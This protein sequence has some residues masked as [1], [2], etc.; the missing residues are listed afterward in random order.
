MSLTSKGAQPAQDG[1]PT[2]RGMNFFLEDRNLQFLCESVMGAA[3]FERARPHLVEMGEVAGGELDDLAAQAD[4]N[5][6]VLRAFDQAG[7]RVDEVVFHPSYRRM[8]TIAFERFGLAALS[9]RDGVLGW[10]GRVPQTVKYALSY[11]FAQSEFGLLCPVNMTDSTARMLKHYASDELKAAW[12]P[13]LTTTDFPQLLQGTQWMTEKTGG[14]DVG[15]ATTLARKGADG[16]WRLWGDKWFCSNAN[17]DVALTLARPE[18][19][20]KGTRG[21]GMFLVP[22]YLPDGTKNGWVINRLKDKFGSRSMASGEV[23]YQGAVA[24]VVGDVGRGFKQMME[25]VNLSR[26]SN[27]MRAAGIMRRALLE[28]VVHASGRAAFGGPLI[29]LP[30]L[31][32]NLMEMLLDVEAAASVVFNAAAVFDRWDGGSVEDRKL[33]R[34]WT[35]IAK[36]WI[37]ARARAVASEAMNVRGGNGYIEEWVN[38]RLVRDSYL[39]AIWEGATPVVALDVQRAIMR[40]QCHEALFAYIGSRLQHVTEPAAKPWVDVVVQAVEALKRRIDGW[41]ALSREELELE[42]KPAAD[43][44]YHLLAASLLLGE[45]Q[46]LRDGAQ[47][48][49]KFLVGALY[50]QRWLLQRDLYAPPFGARDLGWLDALIAWT[51]VPKSALASRASH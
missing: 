13:R 16:T 43:L 51:P 40:E 26:L 1:M 47:D 35:P 10:P 25:M 6:P 18:G 32:A 30:L 37:T 41:A 46:T 34:I 36:C 33:F 42:A 38:A 21:L 3:T 29:A 39:G 50:V 23:T 11:L 31:R 7:R 14:S 24:Y 17:A 49:R 8:E 9:H 28:S 22:K 12:I 4:K 2:T 45:G 19:A 48:F 15:A 5:P 20:P 27:A 44:L